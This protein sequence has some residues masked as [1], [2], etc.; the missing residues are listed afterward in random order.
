MTRINCVPPQELCR[1]HLVAEY[2]ELPR[3]LT[4]VKAAAWCRGERP[5]DPRNPRAYTLGTGHVRFFYPRVLFLHRR[6]TALVQEMD[7]RGYRAALRPFVLF[8]G[9]SQLGKSWLND[10]EPDAA[11]I[12]LNRARIAERLAAMR[13]KQTKE[14]ASC[15]IV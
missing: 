11:A 2:R 10:W 8:A 15:S 5:D 12:A 14:S 1:E 9:V 7:L 3:A 6:F 13:A 4:L